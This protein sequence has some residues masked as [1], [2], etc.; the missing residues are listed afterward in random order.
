MVVRYIIIALTCCAGLGSAQNLERPSNPDLSSRKDSLNTLLQSYRYEDVLSTANEYL[1]NLSEEKAI[2]IQLIKLKALI[3][4]EQF[5]AALDLCRK[6]DSLPL[7]TSQAVTMDLEQAL[8]YEWLEMKKETKGSLDKVESIYANDLPKT[9]INYGNYLI[10]RASYERVLGNPV[11]GLVFADSALRYGRSL[12]FPIVDVQATWLKA[13]MGSSMSFEEKVRELQYADSLYQEMGDM[14]GSASVKSALSNQFAQVDSMQIAFRYNSDAHDAAVKS[15]DTTTLAWIYRRR[16]DFFEKLGNADSAL[17]YLK[18]YYKYD[19][20]DKLRSQRSKIA[21][22]E[23]QT[24]N[25]LTDVKEQSLKSQIDDERRD[26][27]NFTVLTIFLI[28]SLGLLSLFALRSRRNESKI[29]IVLEKSMR[30]AAEREVLLNEVHHRVKNN[31]QTISSLLFLQ[32]RQSN[33]QEYRTL[34]DKSQNHIQSMALVHEMLYDRENV[35]Q[36]DLSTYLKRLTDYL[37]NNYGRNS[38]S[39]IIR[40]FNIQLGLK[41]AIPLG[42]II[43]ELVANSLQHAVA[44][45]GALVIEINATIDHSAGSSNSS[46]EFHYQDNGTMDDAIPA[47]GNGMGTRI[48]SMLCDELD[49]SLT[50]IEDYVYKINFEIS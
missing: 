41:Q 21:E 9:D 4:V 6:L 1:K 26:N 11:I 28:V 40:N 15:M 25:R 17:F 7:T 39:V 8:A 10:R 42:L 50:V 35:S 36:V 30:Q 2:S 12:K 27:R 44:D 16:A 47:S 46:L 18:K 13:F 37:L 38:E 19:T 5:D 14:V 23:Y 34:L 49:A 24:A 48:I 31:L 3:G 33:S 29:S 22:L 20:A 45:R 43:N 32:A